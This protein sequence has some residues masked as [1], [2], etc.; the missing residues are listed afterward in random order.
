V[1]PL[2]L[3]KTYNYTSDCVLYFSGRI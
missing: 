3:L 2:V 1:K